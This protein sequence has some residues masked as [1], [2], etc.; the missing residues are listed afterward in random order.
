MKKIFKYNWIKYG[1]LLVFGIFLGWIFFHNSGADTHHESHQHSDE[2]GSAWTCS[3]HPQIRMDQPGKCPICAMDLIPLVQ[4]GTS[5]TLDPDAIRLTKEAIALADVLTT[6]V[7]R[8]KPVREV[9]LYGRVQADERRFQSQVSQ[10]PGRIEKLFVN[11]TGE[12]VSLG[13][14][15]AEIYSP[16]LVT[17]QQELIETAKTRQLQPELYEASKEKLRQ[18]KLT[19]DQIELVEN[20]GAIIKNFEVLSNTSG[21]VTA[22][23]VSTG[24]YVSQG[25]V[26]FDIADL[27]SVWVLFDAYETDLPFINLG[28]R[29]KFSLQAVPG[30][31]FSGNIVFIDPVLDPVTRVAR[32]RVETANTGGKL[33]PEMFATGIVSSNLKEYRNNIVIPKSA[34][35]WTGKRSIVYVKNPG[36]EEPVFKLREI[37]LGPMLGDSYVVTDGLAEG[38]EIVT[39]GTF[40]VDAAAQLEGKTSMMNYEGGKTNMMT[41]MDMTGDKMKSGSDNANSNPDLKTAIVASEIKIS[42]D[43]INQLNK[44]FDNYIVL[45]NAFVDGDISGVKKAAEEVRRSIDGTDMN[46]ISGDA[47]AQW[48]RLLPDLKKDLAQ[49]SSSDNIQ[50]QRGSFSGFN[51]VFYKVVKTFGLRGKT[52]YYQFCPM[53][54]DNK[55]AYWLSEES[56]IK[57]PYFGDAMLTCGETKET[58]KF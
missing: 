36:K 50:E 39:R 13:Q 51:D 26:L 42:I 34:V 48:M 17:A 47:M 29:V 32:V 35:L 58:L 3:M 12:Q 16:D 38:E 4:S 1:L 45:K 20:S 31:D 40:S 14:K 27:S 24:D 41:G 49:I 46:L 33:K 5:Q 25:T 15:L 18:W 11:F 21:T 52:V 57:N 54:I 55:G 19:D 53:A 23:K 7:S 43:F 28:E 9:R 10:L 30:S 2:Q 37:G 56:D 8:Q 44:V 22:R 6:K